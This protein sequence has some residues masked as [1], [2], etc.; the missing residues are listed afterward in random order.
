[1][2]SADADFDAYARARWPRLV[3][4][5]VLL[6]A[7]PTEAEDVAQEALTQVL[8]KW[9]RVSAVEDRDAYVHRM[10]VNRFASMRRRRWWGE[11]PTEHLPEPPDPAAEPMAAVDDADVLGRAVAALPEAQRA[12]VV[13]RWY[14]H[15]TE[16]QIAE[17]LGVPVGTVKSRTSRA[18][19]ALAAHPSLIE[20][21]ESR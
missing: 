13:L 3:R 12:V 7:T 21:R 6:G 2:S 14:A 20:E 16:A 15:L 4:T 9:E 19:A 11:R 1:M 17:A 10:L 5:A 18:L 8:V